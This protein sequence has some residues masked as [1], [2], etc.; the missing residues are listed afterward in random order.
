MSEAS[1]AAS[2]QAQIHDVIEARA[3][4]I[5]SKNTDRA[6]AVYTR[7]VVNF[8]LPPPLR[9]VGS[10]ALNP[11]GLGGWFATW[12]GPI[13]LEHRDLQVFADGDLAFAHA[14]V[15]L[16]GKRTSGET[17][18]VWVRQTFG[19]RRVDGVWKIAHEH[20]SVPF[21]MDGSYRAAVDL[22]P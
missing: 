22:Q 5:R 13:G 12:D 2:D 17:T 9:F 18:D 3:D 4:A 19:F 7:D 20:T 6:L 15:H 14:L 16:G 21:Y 10:E 8:D 1:N 11:Q